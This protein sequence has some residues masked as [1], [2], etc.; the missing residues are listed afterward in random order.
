MICIEV[1]SPEDTLPDMQERAD[2]Y[3]AVGVPY[4]WIFDPVRRRVWRATSNGLQKMQDSEL[5]VEGTPVRLDLNEV[6]SELREFLGEPPA[7]SL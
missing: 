6:F 2:D 1:L 4:I 7:A 5:A 3:D